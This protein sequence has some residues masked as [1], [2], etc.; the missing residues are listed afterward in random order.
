MIK[1]VKLDLT[2]EEADYLLALLGRAESHLPRASKLH[3]SEV[4]RIL[5]FNLKVS[6]ALKIAES[7]LTPAEA[8]QRQLN[9]GREYFRYPE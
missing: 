2:P 4:R 7:D 5:A 8:E 9:K 6:D 1:P 3:R